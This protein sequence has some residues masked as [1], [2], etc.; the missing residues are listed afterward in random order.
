[1]RYCAFA[2]PGQVR[3]TRNMRVGAV[4][5]MDI[6]EASEFFPNTS[7]NYSSSSR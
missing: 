1:M 7:T 4:G 2:D 5:A 3:K 6:E